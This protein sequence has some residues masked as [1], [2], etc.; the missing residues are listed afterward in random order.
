MS[1]GHLILVV[2]VVAA[3]LAFDFINGFHD[4]ANSIATVVATR[5]PGVPEA[6]RHGQDGVL[7]DPNDADKLAQA[8]AGVVNDCYNWEELRVCAFERHALQFSDRA[9]AAGVAL[10]ERLEVGIMVEVP[11]AAVMMSVEPK[12]SCR[13]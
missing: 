7:A 1:A 10:P 11:S 13:R 9:M 6:I 8:I 3:A 4:A 2:A 5:V 12:W